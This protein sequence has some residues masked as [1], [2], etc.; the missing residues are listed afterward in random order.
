LTQNN[1]ESGDS[2][3]GVK[4]SK[5]SNVRPREPPDRDSSSAVAPPVKRPRPAVIPPSP[6]QQQ[7]VVTNNRH[8]SSSSYKQDHEEDE[9]QEVTPVKSEPREAGPVNTAV[10][11]LDAYQDPRGEQSG[12]GD[13][14]GQLALD[15]AYQEDS[16]D[17]G[18]YGEGYEDNSGIIG[19]PAM[20]IFFTLMNH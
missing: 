9:I 19:M 6:L 1:T 15:E 17:Y 11:P 4:D 8:S 18:D 7:T 14:G 16:Y 13:G 20:F 10:A 3:K 12:G 2:N 5:Q